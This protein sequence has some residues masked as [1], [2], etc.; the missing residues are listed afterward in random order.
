MKKK[1]FSSI[2]KIFSCQ[3]L[4]QTQDWTFNVL[5]QSKS[6]NVTDTFPNACF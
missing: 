1:Y 6:F 3:K 4:S 2:V 5:A